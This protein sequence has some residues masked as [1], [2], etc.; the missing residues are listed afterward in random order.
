M[1][2]RLG[3]WADLSLEQVIPPAVWAALADPGSQV[4][5]PVVFAV[6]ANPERTKAAISVA[7]RRADGSGHVEVAA[8]QS[9]TG[10]VVPWLIERNETWHPRAIALDPASS[11]GAWITDLE[12][13]GI[14]PV[15]V[16][17]REMAQ[18]C[19]AFHEGAVEQR[20]HHLDQDSLNT[21]LR[22]ARKR[23]LA[24]AWAWHRR[25]SNVDITPLVASTLAWHTLATHGADAEPWVM[26]A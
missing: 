13:A 2:E 5:D 7:G 6:D 25:N 20:F 23:E 12:E 15:L 22:G 19:G 3:L 10:W 21:A 11:A 26:F 14:E 4:V 17:G 16:T 24:D 18:A 9:G 8:A 1:R